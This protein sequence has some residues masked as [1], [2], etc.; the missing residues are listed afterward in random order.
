MNVSIQ[1]QGYLAT[2]RP[3]EFTFGQM[4]SV[5]APLL[6]LWHHLS[7]RD[8]R[9]ALAESRR[10][11]RE[12]SIRNRSAHAALLIGAATAE[13]RAGNA[14]E[15]GRFAKRSQSIL[16]HQW[17]AHRIRIAAYEAL[18]SPER[19]YRY[20]ASVELTETHTAWDEPISPVE[21]QV[22]AASLGW[23]IRAWDD[24]AARICRAYPAGVASMPESLQGDWFRL[25]FY[26]NSPGAAA[27]AARAVLPSCTVDQ[28]D[29]LLNAM[30]QQGWTSEALPLYRDAFAY[31]SSSQLL[32]RRLVGLCIKEGEL[33][34][35]RQLT[36]AGALDILA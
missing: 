36:A 17:M 7:S 30:V 10:L 33:E 3:P 14:Q 11:L 6:E 12:R 18:Q 16:P 23:K 19:A 15:A 1:D 35:A 25:A 32:R 4:S 26:R 28:I 5:P 13:L 29:R 2:Y 27:S 31:H 34:E 9:A 8:N 20:A 22:F 24:V 21:F